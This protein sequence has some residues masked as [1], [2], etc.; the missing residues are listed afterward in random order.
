MFRAGEVPERPQKVGRGPLRSLRPPGGLRVRPDPLRLVRRWRV[1]AGA[2]PTRGR[3]LAQPLDGAAP[4]KLLLA[5]LRSSIDR[6]NRKAAVLGETGLAN[7]QMRRNAALRCAWFG[8]AG[9]AVGSF[10]Q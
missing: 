6:R 4:V 5:S 9:P 1:N 2:G 10:G 3:S 7:D 8:I